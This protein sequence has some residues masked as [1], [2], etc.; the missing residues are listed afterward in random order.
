MKYQLSALLLVGSAAAQ[1]T[2]YAYEGGLN[3]MD[4]LFDPPVAPLTSYTKSLWGSSHIPE[5]CHTKL[6]G[7]GEGKCSDA[8]IEVYNVTYSDVS[9]RQAT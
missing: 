7:T 8:A 1:W 5:A 2:N 9:L 4:E 6:G 3:F